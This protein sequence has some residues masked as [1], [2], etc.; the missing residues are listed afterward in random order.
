MPTNEASNL[1]IFY[2]R[3]EMKYIVKL[4]KFVIKM[5]I[6]ITLTIIYAI[7]LLRYT[8][9]YKLNKFDDCLYKQYGCNETYNYCYKSVRY[10]LISTDS[11]ADAYNGFI[12]NMNKNS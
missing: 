7:K 8:I 11:A 9:L 5:V 6:A 3:F 2:R 1:F 4:F 12:K 10:G